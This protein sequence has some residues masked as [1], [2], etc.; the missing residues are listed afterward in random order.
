MKAHLFKGLCLAS[1]FFSTLSLGA[2][3]ADPESIGAEGE[4][5]SEEHFAEEE[6]IPD[7]EE[8][9]ALRTNLS[10]KQEVFPSAARN[11]QDLPLVVGTYTSGTKNPNGERYRIVLDR[12]F[13]A[14]SYLWAPGYTKNHPDEGYGTWAI[15]PAT[16]LVAVTLPLKSKTCGNCASFNVRKYYGIAEATGANKTLYIDGSGELVHAGNSRDYYT[17]RMD[18][19]DGHWRGRSTF[20]WKQID[21][22]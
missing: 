1:F 7:S 13:V 22:L 9:L 11:K 2:C 21:R 19:I 18:Y 12:N 4:S 10:T 6:V 20:H 14:R 3:A 5:P 16:H 8:A 17:G 15:D